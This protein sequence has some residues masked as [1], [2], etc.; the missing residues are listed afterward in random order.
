MGFGDMQ[1]LIRHVTRFTYSSPISESVMEVRMQPRTEWA[2]RCL[3]FDLAPV[4]RARVL[5]YEDPLGNVVHHFDVPNR[6]GRLLLTAD[7]VVEV[8]PAAEVPDAVPMSAWDSLDDIAASG[9]QWEN[10]AFSQFVPDV[11]ALR[12]FARE[13]GAGRDVDP[14]TMLR[15]LNTTVF[16][17]FEYAQQSTRVDSTIEDALE[18]RAGVC[19]DFAHV[20][21]G[22]VRMLGI[23]SR[24]VS[25]YLMP[26][27]ADRSIE[28]ATHAWIEAWL[29]E[30]G[31]VGFDPTNNTL[32]LERHVRVAIGRDYSDV[33]PTRGVF[34]G[35]A[36]SELSVSVSVR[37]ADVPVKVEA[38]PPMLTWTT[39]EPSAE[40][41]ALEQQQQQQ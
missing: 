5:S 18:S 12:A 37:L 16:D 25:G 19:Q 3:R 14:L 39:P 24:Y 36:A 27:R 7:A 41:A 30:V 11:P 8:L 32:A 2:Q 10:L 31:W 17:S 6:H 20:M 26:D 9:R 33:P 22:V 34:K 35:R 15:Q 21:L 28:G 38:S 1:Y 13:T 4:P 23:P 40:A 29:P